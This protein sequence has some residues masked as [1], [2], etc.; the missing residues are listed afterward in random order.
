MD[1]LE[2]LFGARPYDFMNDK[3][4]RI[5][6]VSVIIGEKNANGAVGYIAEKVS[7]TNEDFAAVFGT[8]AEFEKIIMKPVAIS[9]NKR[10]K[11]VAYEL[12]PTQQQK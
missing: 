9:Y 12:I 10:S 6:G 4:E 11:P 2:Y 5:T 1:T 7:M 3:N 8:L